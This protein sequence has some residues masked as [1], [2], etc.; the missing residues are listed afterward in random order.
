MSDEVLNRLD[1]LAA[2][3]AALEL[4]VVTGEVADM[5]GAGH[6]DIGAVAKERVGN[7][8]GFVEAYRHGQEV[9]LA[10]NMED[11]FANLGNLLEQMATV[12]QKSIDDKKGSGE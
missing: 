12:V 4:V 8:N 1:K 7:W 6:A 2:R 11:A 3:I 9:S 5:A 10:Q